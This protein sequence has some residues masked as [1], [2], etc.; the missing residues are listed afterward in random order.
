VRRAE[1]VK[2]PADFVQGKSTLEIPAQARATLLLDNGVETNAFPQL[3]VSGG[4][5]SRLRLVYAEALIDATGGKGNRDEVD[6]RTIAGVTDEFLP[7]G[8]QERL[9]TTLA[10]RTY[11]YVQLEIE[12]AEEALRIDDLRAVFTGYPFAERGS[13]TSDDPELAR[14]WDVGWRTARL[15]AQETY[16]DCPYYE[17]LQYVGDTRIQALI[18][19]YVSGDDRLM[20][21][22]IELYDRSR[23]AEGLTQSRYPSI[24]PQ[25]INTFSLYWI[26]MVH[27]YWLHRPDE[28]F[29]RDRLPGIAAV[30]GWF[31]RKIDPSTG[32]LGPLDYW[33]FVDWTDEWPWDN[34]RGVGGD[35]PGA[36]NGGSAIVSLQLVCTLQR[37]A[38]L[39]RAFGREGEGARCEKQ[40][41]DLI[42]TVRAQ[43]WDVERKMFADTPKRESFSQHANTFAVLS[44]AVAG[45]EATGLIRRTVDDTTLVQASTYFRFYVLRAMK[46]AGLGDEYLAQL[47]PWRTMLDLGLTTFAEKPDPT[48]SDCHAWSASPVYE[49]LA[50]VCGIE[51]ASSGF[52]TVRIEPH[53]GHLRRA[54]GVVPHPRGEIRVAL[55]REGAALK[56]QITLPDGVNGTLR[57]RGKEIPLR[58]GEQT[59][60][61]QP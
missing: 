33:T 37:A 30:L 57:W 61:V 27:D 47:D 60:S 10:F 23:I 26:D 58:E 9:F 24:V 20:R 41:M 13:F 59:L 36:S 50:T 54:D 38:E 45:D 1:G 5:G 4:N 46:K 28:A 35:P 14:V 8:G 7:D 6:G 11:R 56:A 19:L 39:F 21:N 43:C 51:P 29:V 16:V 17:Q 42:K 55:A 25:V 49:L 18:S 12:T 40:A 34:A 48:R 15:C 22:A 31:E 2:V 44:G 52:K 53:L 3:T 32:M